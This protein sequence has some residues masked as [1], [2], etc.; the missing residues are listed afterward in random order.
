MRQHKDQIKKVSTSHQSAEVQSESADTAPTANVNQQASSLAPTI[1]EATETTVCAVAEIR[2]NYTGAHVILAP[3][4]NADRIWSTK[5]YGKALCLDVCV[6]V[7]RVC[8]F[9]SVAVFIVLTP[10]AVPSVAIQ[11][12]ERAGGGGVR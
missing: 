8:G 10:D 6:C 3:E 7:S 5:H 2:N 12:T 9:C 4:A 1:K 11:P